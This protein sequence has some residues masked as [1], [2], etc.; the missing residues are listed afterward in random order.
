MTTK[1]VSEARKAKRAVKGIV[2]RKKKAAS[3]LDDSNSVI[4]F[5]TVE[6]VENEAGET[7]EKVTE[8][9]VPKTLGVGTA[10]K[11]AKAIDSMGEVQA[12]FFLLENLLG[13]ETLEAFME[14]DPDV[15]TTNE[16]FEILSKSTFG[17]LEK[18]GKS[19]SETS[20]E[21]PVID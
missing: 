15:D 18:L 4:L 19:P 5:T 3:K 20:E 16:I 13:K 2:L 21:E 11:F 6:E 12:V 14:F 9:R 8:H 10:M 17:N 7:E 1:N